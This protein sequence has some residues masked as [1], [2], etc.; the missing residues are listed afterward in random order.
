MGLSPFKSSCFTNSDCV[1]PNP[2]PLAYFVKKKLSFA[3]ATLLMVKY[4]G[5]TNFE[6]NK[7]LVFQGDVTPA[8]GLDPHFDE[9][10]ESPIARFKPTDEGLALAIKFCKI[11]L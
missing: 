4:V 1:A 2:N 5:C 7:I 3:N 6:G 10:G 11:L 9:T 8:G